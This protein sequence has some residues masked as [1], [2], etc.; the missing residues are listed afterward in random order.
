VAEVVQPEDIA[1]ST[2]YDREEL[3]KEDPWIFR[4]VKQHWRMAAA[5][6]LCLAL[7]LAFVSPAMA[8]GSGGRAGGSAFSSF[9]GGGSRGFSGSM[10]G[11]TYSGLSSGGAGMMSRSAPSLTR[12]GPTVVNSF[13]WY[14]APY[15]GGFGA[16]VV[17][18]GGGGG[19]GLITILVLGVM[20][21][22]LFS[23]LSG[24][25]DE[26]GDYLG[27]KVTVA[28]LQ[29]GL[30]GSARQLQQ[31]LDRIAGRADTNT[32]DGLHFILQETVLALLR[33]PD[34]CV[35][36]EGTTSRQR[37]L[38]AGESAFNRMSMEERGKVKEETL[39]NVGG[40]S[41]R[42]TYSNKSPSEAA[43]NELI[44][45]T[46]LV[47]AQGGFSL[48]KVTSL[49]ELRT[50]L[51][52]L[53]GISESQTM[54]VEVMWTPQAEDDFYTQADMLNDFPTLNNL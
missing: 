2:S 17:A 48:P 3:Q 38:D 36:G 31:D 54:A 27:E 50:A 51:N 13:G 10:G 34:Y 45:V 32:P 33:N 12:T 30:L 47:A 8:A 53:G 6:A 11:S 25:G 39:V 22:F 42:S 28:K 5:G 19:G 14:G 20:A 26:G 1:P 18:T 52:T 43:K 44:V 23:T 24:G 4:F 29:V 21:A 7:A 40:R 37:G 46:L 35:Y 41:R 49:E 16:P 15:G 9:S